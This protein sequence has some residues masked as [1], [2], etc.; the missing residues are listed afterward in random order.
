MPNYSDNEEEVG[1][2][3]DVSADLDLVTIP[4]EVEEYARTELGETEEMKTRTISEL[5]DMIYEKADITPHRMDNA[6]LLRFLRARN[7]RVEPA[8]RLFVN[9]HQFRENN[10]EFYKDVNPLDLGYIGEAD[11][12]SVMPYREQNGRRIMIFRLGNWNPSEV[13]IEEIFKAALA[14]LELGVLEPRAQILGGVVI[15]DLE[16]FGLQQAWQVTPSVASK[17]LDLMGVSFPMKTTAI[18]IL[19]SSWVF[20]MVFTVFKQFLNTRY[21]DLIH[22]HGNDMESLH[23]YIEPKYLPKRYGGIRPDYPYREW[24]KNLSSNTEI[25]K[26]MKS[27]GYNKK[28][29]SET[30]ETDEG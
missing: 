15:F 13:D 9:Y 2:L 4:P 12:L 21:Y 19:N 16:G 30:S 14:V 11:I 25:V 23:S 26:E 1:E 24:F 3:E 18:H 22:N 28:D 8:F 27:L 5:Q 6:F 7:Y 20:D 29:D 17:V 10:P